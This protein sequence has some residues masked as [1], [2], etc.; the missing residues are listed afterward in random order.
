MHEIADA[1]EAAGLTPALFEA[2]A[3]VYADIARRPLAEA[4]PEDAGSDLAEAL[5]R[6]R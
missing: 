3:D 4:S 1:Q 6:L 2:I 5:R